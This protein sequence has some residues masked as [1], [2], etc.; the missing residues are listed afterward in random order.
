MIVT[1][2]TANFGLSLGVWERRA[3]MELV[4]FWKR[5][6]PHHV[7]RS[8]GLKSRRTGLGASS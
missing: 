1:Y 5:R 3:Q 8:K 4:I 7:S 2:A 6:F